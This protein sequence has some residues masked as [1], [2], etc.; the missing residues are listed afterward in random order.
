MVKLPTIQIAFVYL[1]RT[2]FLA[3]VRHIQQYFCRKEV[4]ELSRTSTPNGHVFNGFQSI[5]TNLLDVTEACE[6][7]EVDA[8]DNEGE[9]SLKSGAKDIVDDCEE[10]DT[11][12]SLSNNIGR[13]SLSSNSVS[14]RTTLSPLHALIQNL[15]AQKSLTISR[16]GAGCTTSLRDSGRRR[17]C[18]RH[19]SGL[20]DVESLDALAMVKLNCNKKHNTY[21]CSA[22]TSAAM[23][24][25]SFSIALKGVSKQNEKKKF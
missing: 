2:T 8:D 17:S 14:S 3:K 16:I 23:S 13:R 11:D 22:S 21:P 25:S 18:L 6:E 1:F 24:S 15:V 4:P 19:S 20:R 12:L 9:A 7:E 10:T 5:A